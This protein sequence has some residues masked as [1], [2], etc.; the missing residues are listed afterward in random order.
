MAPQTEGLF[1]QA[2][3]LISV[4]RE[5]ISKRRHYE[6]LC[7]YP[8]DY[9]DDKLLLQRMETFLAVPLVNTRTE[10]LLAEIEQ[11]KD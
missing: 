3:M 5:V 4:A 6:K 7:G 1:D 8:N 2:I 9:G 11:E 10:E